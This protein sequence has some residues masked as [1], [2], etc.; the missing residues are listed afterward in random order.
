MMTRFVLLAFAG[1]A[2]AHAEVMERS[3]TIAGTTLHYKVVLPKGF[4]AARKYPGVLA[5]SGGP[6][7]MNTVDSVIQRNW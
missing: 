1:G 3:A 4:D 7:T 5:F 6:Q 2:F